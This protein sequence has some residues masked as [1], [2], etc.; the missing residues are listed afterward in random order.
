M[1]RFLSAL[2]A[3]PLAVSLVACDS[4][5]GP[6][7]AEPSAQRS[8]LKRAANAVKYVALG[9]SFASMSGADSLDDSTPRAEFCMRSADSYPHIVAAQIG[10]ELNDATCQ[11]A[12]TADV[13]ESYDTDEGRVFS[14]IESL[15]PDT[16][17]V[18]LTIGG[19][20]VSFG[21]PSGCDPRDLIAG[22]PEVNEAF[23]GILQT[24]AEREAACIAD[25]QAANDEAVAEL[26]DK[27]DEIYQAIEQRSPKAM[28]IATGYLPVI[29]EGDTCDYANAL[30][31]SD[32]QWFQDTTDQLNSTVE[33]SASE[34]GAIYV[35][36]NDA[37][38]HTA[39]TSADDRWTSIDGSDT[40]SFPMHPTPAGQK[41]MADAVVQ[42]YE[43]HV[44]A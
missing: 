22:D 33:Q 14:Q 21:A 18:T 8:H 37:A 26:P 43:S 35:M 25:A 27:L 10:A 5:S 28:V 12:T 15:T 20:D 13:L 38:Q 30:S 32:L 19:N 41:T 39:C 36:P 23:P 4:Q 44:G 40:N 7:G 17:L 29:L 6:Y 31:P 1:K 16:T 34:H 24:D 3:L 11:G 2:V 9:D 42:A